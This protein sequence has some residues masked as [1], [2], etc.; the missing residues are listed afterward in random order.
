MQISQSTFLTVEDVA[1]N[2]K[3]TRQTV[4]K[5]IKNNELN[6]IKINKSYRITAGDFEAFLASNSLIHEPQVAYLRKSKNCSL[7]Y[8]DKSDEFEIL[9]KNTNGFFKAVEKNNKQTNNKFIFGDNLFVLR[10]LL[11]SYRNSIDL[12]YIDPPFGTGQEFNSHDD[13]NAYSDKLVDSAFLEF[14]RKRLIILKEL[15]SENGSIYLHIDKKIGH[16]VKIIMDEIFGY[17]NFINDITRIKC[18]PKNF[19]RSAYGN[20]SD[21]I[22]FYAK[23][24][25]KNIWNEIRE[26]MSDSKREELFAKKHSKYGYYTTNPIHAPGKTLEG[27]TGKEWKGIMP[28][29]GR[30]WRY[31]REV[32]T[33]L[34]KKGLIEW[35]ANGNPRKIVLASEHKGFK[36]QDVWE[37][38]DKGFSYVD[39]PTQ[40]N[41]ELLERIIANSSNENS[42]VL[43]CF[44]GS[45]S[46]MKVAN[47]LR[48]KWI[49]IDNSP[50]SYNIIRKTFKQEDINC[51]FFEYYS[52]D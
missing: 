50:H 41:Y 46:T 15:L 9:Y 27:D 4:S 19:A 10:E 24:R 12:V 36:V 14:L 32:L 26:P 35:S 2:L 40:K 18:N 44:A 39:Y 23:Y 48:R 47:K 20:Y 16:Y 13:I 6:A 37:F 8:A 28:P 11:K 38:K 21:M 42:I 33:E 49:G 25:D 45:G 34:D 3:V 17:K 52:K 31:S 1:N 51:N 22:L 29:K 5:Y 7:D 30:H 43:D